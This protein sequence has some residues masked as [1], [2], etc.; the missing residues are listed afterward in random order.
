M[1]KVSAPLDSR[2]VIGRPVEVPAP[3]SRWENFNDR[4]TVY[5]IAKEGQFLWLATMGGVVRWDLNDDSYSA[6]SVLDGLGDNYVRAV[7]VDRTGAKW[8]GTRG[9]GLSRFDG[10][11]KTWTR[12][13][14]LPSNFVGAVGIAAN[15]DVWAG[16][17][18]GLAVLPAGSERARVI[19]SFGDKHAASIAFDA[20][21]GAW[22]GTVGHGLALVRGTDCRFFSAEDGLPHENVQRTFVDYRGRAWAGTR[23]GL[24]C[25]DGRRWNPVNLDGKPLEETITCIAEDARGNLW[26]GTDGGLVLDAHKNK[27]FGSIG[28][29]LLRFDGESWTRQDESNGLAHN[30]VRAVLPDGSSGLWVGTVDG[31]SRLEGGRWST[32]RLRSDTV[33]YNGVLSAHIDPAGRHWFGTSRRGLCCWD[34]ARWESFADAPG[35]PFNNVQALAVDRAGRLWCGTG[36]GVARFDGR[37]WDRYTKE[38]GLAADY[39]SA[40]AVD[41]EDRVWFGTRGGGVSVFDGKAWSSFNPE[42]TRGA[43]KGRVVRAVTVDPQGRLW[44]GTT[45]KGAYRF[46]GKTWERHSVETGLLSDNV[47]AVAVDAQGVVWL[48]TDLGLS[49]I[50]GR[51]VTNIVMRPRI[52]LSAIKRALSGRKWIA[53]FRYLLFTRWRFVKD[54]AGTYVRTLAVG[55]DGALWVGTLG[56]VNRFDGKQW[57]KYVQP[58]GLCHYNVRSIAIDRENTAWIT[59][60]AGISKLLHRA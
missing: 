46:D 40:V 17:E 31:F 22:I 33:P 56:G 35:S 13:E 19:G 58:D 3:A 50:D 9:G 34:G 27:W 39:V 44:V 6:F 32:Y 7:A 2:V 41:R 5:G 47:Y 38:D 8:F 37:R 20:A 26:V 54:L 59:T 29:G 48:G 10:R 25:F 12:D 43:F 16:T 11:W 57:R 45:G 28:R 14:G 51:R 4:N 24:A 53:P 21:G 49:R 52:L 23:N 1:E 36:G 55:P 60:M 30:N 15:G 18:H 42:T